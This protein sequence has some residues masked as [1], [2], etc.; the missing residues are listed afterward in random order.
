MPA[1]NGSKNTMKLSGLLIALCSGVVMGDELYSN[2]FESG[3]VGNEW[4]DTTVGT[5]SGPFG[6]FLG[7]FG[8]GTVR[9]TLGEVD[10]GNGGDGPGGVTNNGGVRPQPGSRGGGDRGGAG[11]GLKA[12][13]GPVLDLAGGGSGGGGGGDGGFSSGGYNITFDLYLFDSWDG[14]DPVHGIDRFQV[15]T[16][17]VVRLDQALETFEPNENWINGWQVA[18]SEAYDDQYRDLIFSE[19]SLNFSVVSDGDL[20]VIDFTSLQNQVIEDES[21][22]IDNIRVSRLDGRSAAVPAGSTAL[23]LLGGLLCGARRRR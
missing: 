8:A 7:R 4:S 19:I 12:F 10:G 9:L 15:T 2:N 1:L 21:W 14:R 18:G 3:V 23:A 5:T 13:G 16:N 20:I 22:G 6:M 11:G 17:G